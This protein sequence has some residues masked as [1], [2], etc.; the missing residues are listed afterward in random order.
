MASRIS[1]GR[2]AQRGA[3]HR[4]DLASRRLRSP[5]P[6]FAPPGLRGRRSG[7][8]GADAARSPRGSRTSFGL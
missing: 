3:H 2:A 1:N 7:D 8:A 5:W 4:E 6:R